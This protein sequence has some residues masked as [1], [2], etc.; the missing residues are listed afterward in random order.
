M[1]AQDPSAIRGG[2]P[3]KPSLSQGRL[4][5]RYSARENHRLLALANV[6]AGFI[7]D[8]NADPSQGPS[9]PVLVAAIVGA[10]RRAAMLR[11]SGDCG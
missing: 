2:E 7:D 8:R 6:R 10:L 3:Q 5:R 1:K 4:K 11:V 9:D